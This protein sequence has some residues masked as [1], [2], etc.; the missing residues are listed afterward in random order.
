MEQKKAE[1]ESMTEEQK[2]SLRKFDEIMGGKGAGKGGDKKNEGQRTGSTGEPTAAVSGAS[3]PAKDEAAAGDKAIV[4]K[5]PVPAGQSEGAADEATVV[6]EVTEVEMGTTVKMYVPEGTTNESLSKDEDFVGAIETG[7]AD[8]LEVGKDLVDVVSVSILGR[9]NLLGSS[10]H[11][12]KKL[13]RKLQSLE[14]IDIEYVV[15]SAV[16][17]GEKVMGDFVET[18]ESGALKLQAN[19]NSAISRDNN[20]NRNY[21]VSD[22]E[23][24]K[25]KKA[26]RTK[27]SKRVSS[28]QNNNNSARTFAPVTAT[29]V[30]EERSSGNSRDGQFMERGNANAQNMPIIAFLALLGSFMLG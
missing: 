21:V 8:T 27:K 26:T 3:T 10:S 24:T 19:I 13:G 30:S 7:I 5:Q 20:V 22:V 11:N 12:N 29:R 4:R 14:S 1:F 15:E 2:D 6:E 23:E 16:E 17:D 18:L 25:G 9:R 28:E